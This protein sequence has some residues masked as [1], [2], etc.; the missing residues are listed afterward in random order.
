MNG[1]N[2]NH[3][4]CMKSNYQFSTQ[5]TAPVITTCLKHNSDTGI[6]R[7]DGSIDLEIMLKTILTYFETIE[8]D[9]HI[10]TET[11]MI[12]SFEE[13]KKRDEGKQTH[14]TRPGTFLSL[15]LPAFETIAINEWYSFFDA[16]AEKGTIITDRYAT[17]LTFVQ[18][19]LKSSAL[20]DRMGK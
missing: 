20:N 17:L 16:Y 3:P 7:S 19:Y 8:K 15:P 12:K 2:R 9:N 10:V 11:S 1:A 4:D 18:F 14:V 5:F 6:V 13:C